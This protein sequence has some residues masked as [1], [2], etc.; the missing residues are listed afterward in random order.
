ML[1]TAAAA[2]FQMP[3]HPNIP[4]IASAKVN[5]NFQSA[6]EIGKKIENGICVF[7]HGNKKRAA[8]VGSSCMCDKLIYNKSLVSG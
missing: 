7:V 4:T 3:K 2:V 6:K 5:N 8:N 1:S